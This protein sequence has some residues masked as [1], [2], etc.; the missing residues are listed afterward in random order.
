[1]PLVIW[2]HARPVGAD[3]L[4]LG[5]SDVRVDPRKSKRLAHRIRAWA[6]RHRAAAVVIT[7]PLSRSADAGRWLARWGWL[8][9]IDPRLTELDFGQWDGRRWDEIGAAAVDVWCADFAAHAPGG[10][11]SVAQLL[12]R[13]HAV[14]AEHVEARHGCAVGHAGWISAARWLIERGS[15]VPTAADWPAAVGYGQRVALAPFALNQSQ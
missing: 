1:M 3:G 5:R 2:R 14:L 13:C 6:R 15:A 8:H 4:C 11:E 9:R 10:G 12:Q 7:S